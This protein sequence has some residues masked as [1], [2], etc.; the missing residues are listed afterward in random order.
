M[1]LCE[2]GC[3]KPAPI[4][5]RNRHDLGFVKG[6]PIRFIRGHNYN[7]PPI[8]EGEK[9]GKWKGGRAEGIGYTRILITTGKYKPEHVIIAEIVLGKPLPLGAVVHHHNKIRSDNRK[10]NLVICEN[11]AYHQH[12]HKRYRAYEATGN[13]SSLKCVFC[14]GWGADLIFDKY[15]HSYHAK[16]KNLYTQ[17][18]RQRR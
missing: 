9:N 10:P 6:Q 11:N 4:P 1:K 12:I 13:A 15:R 14:K 3:G 17:K 7:P 18:I 16:C 2:C 8:N 5:K